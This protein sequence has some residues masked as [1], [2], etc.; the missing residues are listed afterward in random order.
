MNT[1]LVQSVLAGF[2][3][4]STVIQAQDAVRLNS[5]RRQVMAHGYDVVAYFTDQKPVKGSDQFTYMWQ[6]ATW[7]FASALHRDQFAKTPEKFAPQ[8]GGFCA[9]GVSR[10]YTVDIDPEAFT[11]VD[12]RLFLNYSKKVRAV[13]ENERLANITKADA[14]WPALSRRR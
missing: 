10:N 4:A 14:N 3:L 11:V 12:G 7:R 1:T 9:Y 2:I 5:D 13:W 8:Y 6:G